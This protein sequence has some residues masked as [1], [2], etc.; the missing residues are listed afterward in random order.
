MTPYA[1][2]D[3]VAV[4]YLSERIFTVVVAM[5]RD[6]EALLWVNWQVK[7]FAL[8][9]LLPPTKAELAAEAARWA[10]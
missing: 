5:P 2:G 3:Y 1:T 4:E 7:P 9:A 10:R 8:S 6:G